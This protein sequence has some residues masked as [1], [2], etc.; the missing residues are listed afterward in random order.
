MAK[1]KDG[2]LYYD[3][4]RCTVK[5]GGWV[6]ERARTDKTTPNDERVMQRVQESIESGID[7][8]TLFDF[9]L[10]LRRSGQRPVHSFCQLPEYYHK[11]GSRIQ[12]QISPEDET[13]VQSLAG[14]DALKQQSRRLSFENNAEPAAAFAYPNPTLQTPLKVEVHEDDEDD[15]DSM[16]GAVAHDSSSSS[17]E[18]D[19]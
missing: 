1:S 7:F 8:V 18:E 16:G 19:P 14:V 13:E 5:E 6:L 3:Y 2:H 11:H 4:S 10:S 12:Q 9:I 17:E 15:D